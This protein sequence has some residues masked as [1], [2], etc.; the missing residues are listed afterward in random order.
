MLLAS[1]E[2]DMA[3]LQ[4]TP[5]VS[6]GYGLGCIARRMGALLLVLSGGFER[7]ASSDNMNH[8]NRRCVYVV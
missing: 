1:E 4:F 2:C 5:L 6:W 7:L 8:G 3:R